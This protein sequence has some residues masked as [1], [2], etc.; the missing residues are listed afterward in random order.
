MAQHQQHEVQQH[1]DAVARGTRL[2]A[3]GPP[4]HT[5]WQNLVWSHAKVEVFP[6]QQIVH[7]AD[8][9]THSS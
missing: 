9:L 7:E 1:Y 6:L 2:L 8:H 4:L 3:P 5:C